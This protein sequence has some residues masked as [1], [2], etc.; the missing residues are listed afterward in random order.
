MR[1]YTSINGTV[2]VGGQ[3][4]IA[5]AFVFAIA[6]GQ[7]S[8][9]GITDNSGSY[10][11]SGLAPGT[12]AVTVDKTG[13]DEVA[14][15][16]ATVSY[17]NTTTPTGGQ[18]STPVTQSVSFTMSGTTSVSATRAN[19][20]KDYRLE[21]NYP[22]PFNPSTMISFALPQ[23]G[24]T[25]LKVYNVLGQE[26]TTLLNG[27]QTGGVHQVLFNA[28]KL[29]SGVYFYELQSGNFVQSKKMVLL[30]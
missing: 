23:A 7:V 30:K 28:D 5:G 16:S 20:V 2:R 12:Y 25:T 24:I 22:N 21:Q 9:Y 29:S 17:N 10:L 6:G 4:A 3:G 1:G 14:S 11:I 27:Y 19:V 8:G 13:F 18:T 26:V 15:Q